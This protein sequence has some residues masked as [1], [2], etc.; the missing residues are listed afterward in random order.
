[1]AYLNQPARLAQLTQTVVTGYTADIA[2]RT[3]PGPVPYD[4]PYS[5]TAAVTGAPTGGPT[6]AG[7]VVVSDPSGAQVCTIDLG[8]PASGCGSVAP[9][10]SP[11]GIQTWTAAYSGDA[12][13]PARTVTFPV[14]LVAAPTTT[15]IISWPQTP[16]P[17]G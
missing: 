10:L 17:A 7:T 3:D 9:S 13:Y 14:T 16:W 5:I 11:A 12:T 4:T 8:P 6:P 2:M 15:T 1:D